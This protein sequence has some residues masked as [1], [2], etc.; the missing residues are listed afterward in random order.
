MAMGV[1]KGI[2]GDIGLEAAGVV[3]RVGL[4]VEDLG[5]GD[6][7]MTIGRGLF[8]TRAVLNKGLVFPIPPQLTFEEAASIPAIFSTA[9]HAIVEKGELESGQSVLIHSACGGVGQAALQICQMLNADI[10]V[11]VGSEEKIRYLVENFGLDRK[12]I[13]NSRDDSFYDDVM[14]ATHGRGVDL[15]INSLSGD[16]LH[17]SWRCVA[18]WGKMMEIGKRDMMESG[19]LP[20][21]MFE[22]N[23][24]FYG[25]NLDGMIERPERFRR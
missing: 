4:H 22:G 13:F 12:R 20:L 18:Q 8:T 15:V 14:R 6:R 2:Q 21:D 5:V 23:R 19:H 11:T 25:I 9:V 17:A 24:S 10:Y 3:S 7:V 1:L 16:L